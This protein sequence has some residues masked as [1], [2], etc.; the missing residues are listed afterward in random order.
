MTDLPIRKVSDTAFWG[1]ATIAA[2]K[3]SVAMP[4]F[5]DPLA[6]V[7]WPESAAARIA[8]DAPRRFHIPGS[9][10]AHLHQSM[11]SSRRAI[12]KVSTQSST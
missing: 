2:W 9:S 11:T 5:N 3:A 1:R 6:R 7:C 4:L 10:S 12:L 8:Q